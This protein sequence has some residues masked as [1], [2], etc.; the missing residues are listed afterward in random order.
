MFGL[1][2]MIVLEVLGVAQHD[3]RQA[4]HL[5]ARLHRSISHLERGLE[6]LVPAHILLE[7]AA[8]VAN[9]AWNQGSEACGGD[10]G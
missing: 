7:E 5:A 8:D 2:T 4:Q 1:W 9:A 3:I 10:S 6:G